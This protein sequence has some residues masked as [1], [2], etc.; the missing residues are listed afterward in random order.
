MTSSPSYANRDFSEEDA[1]TLLA[2]VEAAQDF[3]I[4]PDP[5]NPDDVYEHIARVP[6]RKI[7]RRRLDTR[8][9]GESENVGWNVPDVRADRRTSARQVARL[10]RARR[11][12]GVRTV[13]NEYVREHGPQRRR[14]AF[15]KASFASRTRRGIRP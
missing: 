10:K 12:S 3:P 4:V 15:V 6:R 8:R 5:E 11:D 7:T 9:A 13:R 1:R 14:S 2:Q